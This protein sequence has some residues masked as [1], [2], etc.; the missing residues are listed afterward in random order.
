MATT[1]I[2]DVYDPLLF[3]R[4]AQEAAIEQNKFLN[5]GIAVSDALIAQQVSGGGSVLELPQFSGLTNDEPDYSSDN[6]ASSSTAA[7]VTGQKQIARV[8][9]RNKSWSVMSL[10]NELALNKPVSAITDRQGKYWAVDYEKRL[11]NSSL[12]ILADNVANDSSDMLETVYSDVV[13]GSITDAMK[14]SGSAVIDTVQTLGDH[15]ENISA[16][17]MHSKPHADLQKLGLLVDN[18]DPQTGNVRYQ[19]YLGYMV[20]VDDSLPVEAGTNSPKY[21]SIL[22]GAGSFGTAPAP[23]DVPSEITREALIGD[24]GGQTI[25][26]SR[27]SDVI[28]PYGFQCLLPGGSRI[29]NNYNE[30]SAATRWDRVVDRKNVA[31]AFLETN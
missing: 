21:T 23:V 11:I 30:L 17:A 24:G 10:A 29:A 7:K 25:L 5:S 1:Q 9:P 6:P 2:A 14:I 26:T 22:Y 8:A 18:L 16:I 12:G 27:M 19:T 28:H 3:A 15:K 4:F 20:I 31:L 13:S